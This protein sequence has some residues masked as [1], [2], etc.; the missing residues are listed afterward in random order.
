M[1][2]LKKYIS[3]CFLVVYACFAVGWSQAW[4]FAHHQYIAKTIQSNTTNNS[5]DENT[6]CGTKHCLQDCN[7]QE[8]KLSSNQKIT[9]NGILWESTF[10]LY[11]QITSLNTI[12]YFPQH[13]LE[14]NKNRA[15]P[16]IWT[17]VGIILLT[18]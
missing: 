18:I 10:L 15:W 11:T 6:C 3:I 17:Y 9:E 4:F 16:D 7:T 12:Y 13:K 2:L 8:Y 5:C 1:N 14:E